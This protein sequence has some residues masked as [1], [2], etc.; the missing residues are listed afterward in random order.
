MGIREKM[1]ERSQPFL[2]PGERVH[3]AIWCQTGGSPWLLFLTTLAT[4][5]FKYRI[6]LVTDRAIVVLQSSRWMA[7]P[8][9]PLARLPRHLYFG[10]MSGVWGHT[11]V[12]GEKLYIHRRFHKDVQAADAELQAMSGGGMPQAGYGQPAPAQVPAQAPAAMP[13]MGAQAGA[14]GAQA[15]PAAAAGGTPPGWYPDPQAPGQI[16]WFDGNRW[17]EHARPAT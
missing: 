14:M 10:P 13:A 15:A 8:K 11:E 9:A 1:V 2:E 4:L 6:V 7:K 5:F 12:T 17:T 16:R 3:Q